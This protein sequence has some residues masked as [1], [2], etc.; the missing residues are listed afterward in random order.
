MIETGHAVVA[1]GMVSYMHPHSP[2]CVWGNKKF[3]N[4]F[5]HSS[6]IRK[7]VEK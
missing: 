1:F 2:A 3:F 6:K 5:G 4:V 7:V